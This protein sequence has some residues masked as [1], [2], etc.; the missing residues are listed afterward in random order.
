MI[1][2]LP[3]H[4]EEHPLRRIVTGQSSHLERLHHRLHEEQE[5]QHQEREQQDSFPSPQQEVKYRR[6]S[7]SVPQLE[8]PPA[9]PQGTPAARGDPDG[10]DDGGS[11]SHNT[12][13]LEEQEPKGWVA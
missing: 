12:E 11:L 5:H 6:Q 13:L 10:D 1:P 4:L 2:F 7:S 3:S 9:P 8:V